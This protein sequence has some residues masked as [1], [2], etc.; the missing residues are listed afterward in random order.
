M[1]SRRGFAAGLLAAALPEPCRFEHAA[2]PAAGAPIPIAGFAEHTLEAGGLLLRWPRELPN[3]TGFGFAFGLD[4]REFGNIAVHLA[5]SGRRLALVNVSMAPRFDPY[6][7][8]LAA[9]DARAAS[10][11]GLLLRPDSGDAR[12]SILSA[13][14]ERRREAPALHPHLLVPG[15]LKPLDEYARRMRSL[16]VVQEFDWRAGCVTEG[17]HALNAPD[18]LRRYLRLFLDESPREATEAFRRGVEQTLPAAAI[19]RVHREHPTIDD[20]LALWNKRRTAAGIVQDSTRIVAEANYTVAYPM[21]LLGV[22]RDDP[23]LRARAIAQL[24]AAR[25][26]LLDPA[27]AIHLRHDESTGERTYLGWARGVAWY[28]LGLAATLDA[29]PAW[30]HPRDLK[31]ELH[32]AL[33]WALQYQRPDGLFCAFLPEPEVAPDTSGSAGIAAAILIAHRHS[34]AEPPWTRAARRALDGCIARLTPHGF[35]TG[36]SQSNKREGGP[37]FQRSPHRCNMQFGMG[38]L[39][40]LIGESRRAALPT[41]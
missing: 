25:D 40:V 17:L 29:L 11:E 37:A 22:L 33:A 2:L 6:F 5:R 30:E 4:Y 39:G 3:A 34:I 13:T 1:L 15:Q 20:A 36:V 18:A 19:L 24:R 23:S 10:R 21:A 35:L 9:A 31:D 12:R 41:A 38:F 8:P 14:P 26:R 28:I 32:R 27:G 7:V 16:D